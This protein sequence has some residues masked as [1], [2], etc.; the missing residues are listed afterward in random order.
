MKKSESPKVGKV[1]K[2]EKK[3]HPSLRNSTFN[4]NFFFLQYPIGYPKT[5]Q[6]AM[7]VIAAVN[8]RDFIKVG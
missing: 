5:Q 4:I 8:G 2:S 3:E 1:R 7:R 6:F